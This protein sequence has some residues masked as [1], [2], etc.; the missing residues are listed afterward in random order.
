MRGVDRRGS[1]P[2]YVNKGAL[3][4]TVLF[5]KQYRCVSPFR[6]LG[7]GRYERVS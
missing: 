7:G 4:A 2:T 5:K 6:P 1:W 3:N